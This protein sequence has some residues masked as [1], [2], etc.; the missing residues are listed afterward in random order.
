MLAP[1]SHSN[2]SKRQVVLHVDVD[3]FFASVG[4]RE[5]TEL[6]GFPVA[7]GSDPKEGKG[8]GVVCTYCRSVED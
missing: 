7:V 4:I 3:S 1:N 8:R 6:K 2:V 5:H